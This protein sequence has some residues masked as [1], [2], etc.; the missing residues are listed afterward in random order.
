MKMKKAIKWVL[1]SVVTTIII[2]IILGIYK[3][4]YLANQPEYDCDGNKIENVN[5]SEILLNWFNLKT[6]NQFYIKLPETN[7]EC[8]IS[9]IIDSDSLRY[10]KGYYIDGDEKGEVIIDNRE[11]LA[12]NQSTE[13]ITYLVIPFSIS[14]QGS[15]TFKYLGLF[16][17]NYKAKTVNQI[18]SY[19]LGDRVKINS[20]KYDGFENLQVELKIHSKNQA[21]AEAPSE[22]KL[23][24]FKVR[25]GGSFGFKWLK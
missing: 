13:N 3:F 6:S 11:I 5:N 12:I 19:F 7:K 24:K 17:I 22:L 23:L 25:N 8:K 14:N 4:N 10:A 16:E 21:M 18:D 1:I 9:E 2:V 20:M 15:G